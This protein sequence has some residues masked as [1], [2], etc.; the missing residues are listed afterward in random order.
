VPCDDYEVSKS[1]ELAGT[2]VEVAV[3]YEAGG[4]NELNHF[5]NL[6]G[7]DDAFVIIRVCFRA[8]PIILELII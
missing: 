5:W 2:G 3:I 8:S 4:R 6:T 1:V 7:E